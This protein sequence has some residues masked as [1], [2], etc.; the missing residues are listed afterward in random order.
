MTALSMSGQIDG[1][2]Q[3]VP[4][5]VKTET[6]GG[7]VNG[8][9]VDGTLT[10]TVFP[11]VTIQP[12]NDNELDLLLRAETRILDVR[13]LYINSGNLSVLELNEDVEFLS[14]RWKVIRRDYRPWRKYVKLIVDRYDDQ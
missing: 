5:T 3:T 2:F 9:W 7:Y 13:K 1:V 14:Q 11:R 12:L 8:V 10:S 4:V 6:G